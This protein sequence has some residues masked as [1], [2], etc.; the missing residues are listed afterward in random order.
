MRDQL[1]RRPIPADQSILW[2][3]LHDSHYVVASL[4]S[5]DGGRRRIFVR[6]PVLRRIQR[7]SHAHGRHAV[8][9]LLG[10]LC[11][12]PDSGV[13]YLIVES[14]DHLNP[15]SDENEVA[16]TVTEAL[17]ARSTEYHPHVVAPDEPRPQVIGWYRSVSTV[18][19]K[20][21]ITTAGVHASLFN[22]PWQITL[23]VGE[24]TH[25]SSG[26]IYLHDTLNSRWFFAPFYELLNDPPAS[27]D[28]PKPTVVDWPQYLTAD[29]IVPAGAEAP[30]ELEVADRPPKTSFDRPWLRDTS[31][32]RKLAEADARSSAADVPL[33]AD[34]QPQLE[35]ATPVSAEQAS[36]DTIDPVVVDLP[37]DSI[38][39]APVDLVVDV[40]PVADQPQSD[41]LA[42]RPAARPVH[43]GLADVPRPIRERPIARR[44]DRSEKLSIVDDRDQRAPL[45]SG[46]RRLTDDDDTT[47]G[48]DPGRFIELARTE[49]FF[50]ASRFDTHGE[51]GHAETLWVLNEPYSGMLLAVVATDSTVIDATLHYNLQ[52]DDAGLQRTPFP[53]HRDAESKTIYV[54]E[55]CV[56]SLRA[57][58]RRLRATNSL[59]R[60]WKVTPTISFLTPGE[61]ES[62]PSFDSASSRGVDAVSQLNNARIAELPEGVRAQFHLAG[63]NEV[64][65]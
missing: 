37:S 27:A 28:E 19:T 26:A 30:L 36:S 21:S 31:A 49:G 1:L 40:S 47:A 12:C 23:V 18:E 52:T 39:N 4:Q 2:K 20:P 14:V 8:G 46:R 64:S 42:D 11:Q 53:E 45:Q 34:I 9:L 55:T 3:P 17:A 24:D 50:V 6:Q 60:E 58:C 15:V 32:K 22:Q 29:A 57:R 38:A 54:R 62:V 51:G 7:A 33:V 56:D 10:H 43:A 13:S 61:W 59:L 16:V 41:R 48:D 65:A 25:G 44:S 63:G 5:G 35:L